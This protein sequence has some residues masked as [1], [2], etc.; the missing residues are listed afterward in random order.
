MKHYSISVLM[1][2]VNQYNL[3]FEQMDVKI[4]FL[5]GDL[6][7]IIYM[8]KPKGFVEDKVNICLLKKYLYGLK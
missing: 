8:K 1:T 6:K 4:N 2:I 7:E 5:H 3:G